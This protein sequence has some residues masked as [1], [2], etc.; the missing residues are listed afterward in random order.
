MEN[1]RT[2]DISFQ[3]VYT[4]YL[5][6][7]DIQIIVKSSN[8]ELRRS[9]EEHEIKQAGTIVSFLRRLYIQFKYRR[10]ADLPFM[11]DIKKNMHYNDK[12]L[13]ERLFEEFVCLRHE[14]ETLLLLNRITTAKDN[15]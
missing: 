2:S 1:N 10:K 8:H 11:Q 3:S 4:H 5:T 13:F 15:G 12:E 9:L 14:Y 6:I 7:K